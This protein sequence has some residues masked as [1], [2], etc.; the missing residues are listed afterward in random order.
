M[1]DHRNRYARLRYTAAGALAALAA[2]GAI[3]GATALAAKGGA[4]KAATSPMPTKTQGSQPGPSPQVFLDAIRQLVDNGTITAAQGQA[5]DREIEAG[6]VD[7]DTLASSGFTQ[8]QLDAVQ[9]ALTNTKLSLASAPSAH[10][11]KGA[12][13]GG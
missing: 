8:A 7:T 1:D 2:A 11:Q 10:A 3:A 4:P 13:K 6:R 5:V 9:R 12:S